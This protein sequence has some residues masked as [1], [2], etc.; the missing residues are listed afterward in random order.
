LVLTPSVEPGLG[1]RRHLTLENEIMTE[2]N[3]QPFCSTDPN[4][5][6]TMGKP[7]NANGK[8]YATNGHILVEVELRES[9]IPG[10]LDPVKVKRVV[11]LWKEGS[12]EKLPRLPRKKDVLCIHCEGG[13]LLKLCDGCGG[14][15]KVEAEQRIDIGERTLNAKYLRL[16]KS[17]PNVRI[18]PAGG[19]Q[20]PLSFKFDGGRGLLMPMNIA[21]D[22]RVK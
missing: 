7:F 22:G 1:A 5:A 3:L 15:G 2:I 8:T 14:T 6:E 12:W 11:D 10:I 16:M 21:A 20:E 18:N 17:L 9:V 13:K 4:R 19:Y